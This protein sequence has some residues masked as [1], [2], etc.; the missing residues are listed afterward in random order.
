MNICVHNLFTYS[1]EHIH[2]TPY[3]DMNVR[4]AAQLLSTVYSKVWTLLRP[5]LV[6]W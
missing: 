4:L 1:V 3:F 6:S 2:L 5:D